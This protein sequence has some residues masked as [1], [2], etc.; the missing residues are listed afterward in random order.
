MDNDLQIFR[1][2]CVTSGWFVPYH[3]LSEPARHETSAFLCF[4]FFLEPEARS[5]SEQVMMIP[6][7]HCELLPADQKVSWWA[8]VK[9]HAWGP[10]HNMGDCFPP[11]SS[12][13]S[14]LRNKVGFPN[15]RQIAL[16]PSPS[17][18]SQP[19]KKGKVQTRLCRRRGLREAIHSGNFLLQKNYQSRC[20]YRRKLLDRMVLLPGVGASTWVSAANH[21]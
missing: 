7:L 2:A 6:W 17:Q 11:W 12:F 21:W 5:C 19:G 9:Y 10:L 18:Q 3:D 13:L 1:V 8:R 15:H 4:R 14:L 20:V 16:Q